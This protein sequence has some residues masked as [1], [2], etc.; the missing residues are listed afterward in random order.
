MS[1]AILEIQ[2]T[3][4][5]NAMKF[6]LDRALFA[7]TVSFYNPADARA[8]PI[9]SQLMAIPGVTHVMLL[10]DFVTVGKQSKARW[11]DINGHVKRIM[12]L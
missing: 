1:A 6:V 9:A 4:N 10:G 12:A 7:E 5:P 8:N 2:A 11:S 3:P